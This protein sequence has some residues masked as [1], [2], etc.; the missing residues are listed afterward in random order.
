MKVKVLG[1]SCTW[2]KRNNTSFILDDKIV[3]D[4]PFGNYKLI[5]SYMDIYDIKSVIITHF[6]SDHFGDLNVIATRFMRHLSD[7]AEK[8]KIY[9]PKGI[10]EKLIEYNKVLLGAKDECDP[11]SL[12]KHID[13]IEVCDG[14]EFEVCGYKVKAFE[15]V[16]GV[17]E[18]YG[19]SFSDEN[20]KTIVFS[21]DTAMCD[22][23]NLMLENAD[24]AFVEMSDIRQSKTHLSTQEFVDLTKKYSKTKFYPVHTSD[25][26]QEF[27]I[28]NGLNYLN[29]GDILEV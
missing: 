23:L 9:G 12:T 24:V 3:F 1:T 29:D 17:P 11:E 7:D 6:H 18:T 25:M 2:F 20:G 21:A 15:M 8:L 28:N 14:F 19:F 26:S 5:N 16:H 4:V 27:A 10:L 13:F 22:N